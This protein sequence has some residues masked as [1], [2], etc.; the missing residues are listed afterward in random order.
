LLKGEN[1]FSFAFF[2]QDKFQEQYDEKRY[3]ISLTK[4]S[5]K[6]FSY[7]I[8]PYTSII[9]FLPNLSL[10]PFLE[11]TI[12]FLYYLQNCIE[13]GKFRGV[14]P[15]FGNKNNILIRVKGFLYEKIQKAASVF[16]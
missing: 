13:N 16:P 5:F 7:Y 15:C 14:I 12:F 11:K 9:V 4:T 3:F 8:S 10:T 2:S 6:N 1:N